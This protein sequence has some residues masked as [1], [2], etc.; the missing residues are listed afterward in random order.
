[1][2]IVNLLTIYV[3]ARHKLKEIWYKLHQI[4]KTKGDSYTFL[5]AAAWKECSNV[6]SHF[7]FA[8]LAFAAIDTYVLVLQVK[9]HS[10]S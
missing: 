1:M 7:R 5:L 10:P 2:R 4:L 6:V 9:W 8:E 3:F